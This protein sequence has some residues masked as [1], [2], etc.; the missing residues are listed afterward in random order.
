[1]VDSS[2]VECPDPVLTVNE[3]KG[4]EP[5]PMVQICSTSTHN[6]EIRASAVDTKM[7]ASSRARVMPKSGFMIG[8]HAAT[9][10]RLISNIRANALGTPPHDTS[11]DLTEPD[12]AHLHDPE[13]HQHA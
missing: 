4:S 8:T 5:L 9:I 11:I 2:S 12:K 1:M 6:H 10:P 7:Y 3:V 13:P